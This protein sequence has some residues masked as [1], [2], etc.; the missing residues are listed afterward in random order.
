MTL[1]DLLKLPGFQKKSAE[2]LLA[3]IEASK[4]QGLARALFGLGIRHVGEVAAQ[5][6]ARHFGSIDRLMDA[7]VEEIEAVHTIGGVMAEALHAWFAEPRNRQVVEKLREAGVKL[8]EERAEPAVGPFT[9]KA[10][11][12]TGTHPTMSRTEL[13]DFIESRGGRITGSVT[14]K[15][16]YLVV[17]EDAGSKLAKARELG[18]A[19]LTEAQLLA[20]A[21]APP[22]EGS[23]PAVAS[24]DGD[25]SSSSSSEPDSSQLGLL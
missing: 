16:D 17:G 25:A 24:A 10:F 19:E 5:T 3:G 8:T 20:L 4:Q 12:I 22:A 2:N 7:S 18:V 14:K 6:L 11:V 9:G 21:D 13:T 1:N 15:T 23:D